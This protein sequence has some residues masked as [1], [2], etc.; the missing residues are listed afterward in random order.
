ML[1]LGLSIRLGLPSATYE[2][3]FGPRRILFLRSA[4]IRCDSALSLADRSIKIR[5][6]G[7]SLLDI[8]CSSIVPSKVRLCCHPRREAGRAPVAMPRNKEFP[9]YRPAPFSEHE[10][11]SLDQDTVRGSLNFFN[12]THARYSVDELAKKQPEPAEK[13]SPGRRQVVVPRV[14]VQWRSRNN[15]KGLPSYLSYLPTLR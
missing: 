14:N 10:G 8:A 7:L 6:R 9:S 13:P 5:C 2:I 15:R 12:P 11:V 4:L 1:L 3:H